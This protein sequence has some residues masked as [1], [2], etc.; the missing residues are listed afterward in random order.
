MKVY[1]IQDSNG[2]GMGIPG[3][4]EVFVTANDDQRRWNEL[5]AAALADLEENWGESTNE[6]LAEIGQTNPWDEGVFFVEDKYE[7]RRWEVETAAAR[8]W[9]DV[10]G[11]WVTDPDSVPIQ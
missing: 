9:D 5:V 8:V 11:R 4:P 2:E 10:Q 3:E 1:I 6:I 7:Y